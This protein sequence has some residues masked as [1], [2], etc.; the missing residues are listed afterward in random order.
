[1]SYRDTTR[2]REH[3]FISVKGGY[4]DVSSF[5]YKTEMSSHYLFALMQ[6]KKETCI[7]YSHLCIRVG[8]CLRH[9]G[10]GFR[11]RG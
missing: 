3:R 6:C 5:I 4:R 8:E 9:A 7:E 1:M 10:F 11:G 2:Y